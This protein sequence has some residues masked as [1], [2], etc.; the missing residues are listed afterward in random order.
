MV[1]TVVR[2]RWGVPSAMAALSAGTLMVLVLAQSEHNP[3]IGRDVQ[4]LTASTFIAA[5]P[6][7]DTPK[8]VRLPA[9]WR[10][11]RHATR[12]GWFYL[13]FTLDHPPAQNWDLLLP[14][15]RMNAR[16]YV[17]GQALFGAG[18][19]HS[20]I[21][22]NFNHP[23]LLAIPPGAL[24]QGD[25]DIAVHLATEPAGFG[26]LGR[27][28]V[29]PI[30]GLK[31]AYL[32]QFA[33]KVVAPRVITLSMVLIGMLVGAIWLRRRSDTTYGWFAAATLCWAGAT[34]DI[35]VTDPLFPARLW[36]ALQFAA[37]TWACCFYA[38]F[39]LQ[40]IGDPRPRLAQLLWRYGALASVWL[41]FAPGYRLMY[42]VAVDLGNPINLVIVGYCCARLFGFYRQRLDANT[43]VMWC[44]SIF[45]LPFLLHD[46]LAMSDVWIGTDS[47]YQ[48]FT[49]PIMLFG[50]L[51]CL[52]DR[53][54]HALGESETLNRELETRVE[55]K[56]QEL[57]TSHQRLRA[58][59]R[60]QVL[61]SERQRI[62]IDMH[63]G[64]GGRLI[65]MLAA[66]ERGARPSD[67]IAMDL[68]LALADLRLLIDSLDPQID[69]LGVMIGSLHEHC[70]R[71]IDGTGLTLQ[72]SGAV[73]EADLHANPRLV[74]QVLSIS[75]ECFT[76]TLKHAHASVIGVRC[77]VHRLT[78]DTSMLTIDF[79][80]DGRGIA[81]ADP[82]IT[83]TRGMKS[84]R[85]RA[86]QI[87]G[88][89]QVVNLSPGTAIRLAVPLPHTSGDMESA[90]NGA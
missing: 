46:T 27:L 40:F 1:V 50:F 88:C 37:S 66:T 82:P 9:H 90:R 77:V 74:L 2:K 21:T 73:A 65:S 17:N 62:M 51:W 44:V 28:Y 58:L 30:S 35:C 38:L 36:D 64:I 7:V 33:M 8:S 43:L 79:S 57:S 26:S 60:G 67:A 71:W 4:T 47:R 3:Q 56:A 49:A 10:F 14:H 20:P 16:V 69:T 41:L 75:R 59:E 45:G 89:L 19:L 25:N 15:L 42:R 72:W 23:L 70:Q 32:K 39:V 81:T 86:Q 68:R 83:S 13:H 29:G 34:T 6:D 52:I 48:Y 18:H 12:D 55:R 54:T 87:G 85:Q 63:D 84:M 76:N 80:D 22:R 11:I 31:A 5:G 24:R 53:F 61:T 78:P